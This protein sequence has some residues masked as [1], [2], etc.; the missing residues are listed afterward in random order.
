[1]LA[2][3][4]CLTFVRDV[5]LVNKMVKLGGLFVILVYNLFLTLKHKL[6]IGIFQN[7]LLKKLYESKRKHNRIGKT[8]NNGVS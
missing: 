6:V 5:G 2:E 7:T 1:M 4:G 8:H 3:I